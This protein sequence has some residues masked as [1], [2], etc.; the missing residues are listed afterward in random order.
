MASTS[1]DL[2]TTFTVFPLGIPFCLA[3]S[4]AVYAAAWEASGHF[5]SSGAEVDLQ[6]MFV[7]PGEPEYH[8]L[9]A[10]AGDCKQDV[11]GMLVVGYNHVNDFMDAPSHVKRSVY[12]V[13]QD[14]LGQLAGQ[15]FG[16]GNKVL[17]NE[18]SGSTGIN[19]GF[20]G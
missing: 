19:H 7:Q 17:V 1:A 16:L 18:V 12:V 5:D 14:Q 13:N 9:L 6:I 2:G 3:I 10:E 4:L 15:K 11:F 8:A 20:R